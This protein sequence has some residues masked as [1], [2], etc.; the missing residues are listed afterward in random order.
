MVSLAMGLFNR[1]FRA[2][3]ELKM[4]F[5]FIAHNLWHYSGSKIGISIPASM[6]TGLN[7]GYEFTKTCLW[8]N[9]W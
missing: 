3:S 5:V 2:E 6:K 9:I 4:W 8:T 7:F 1:F